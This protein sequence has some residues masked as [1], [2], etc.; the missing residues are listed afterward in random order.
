[1]P[2]ADLRSVKVRGTIL[3]LCRV[4]VL[5]LVTAGLLAGCGRKGPPIMPEAAAK[6]EANRASGSIVP[7]P[8]D[9]TD[10]S[11]LTKPKRDFPLDPL[12]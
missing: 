8:G 4:A 11:K 1:L 5:G 10:S 6:E 12:L 9:R 3:T 2:I 7:I